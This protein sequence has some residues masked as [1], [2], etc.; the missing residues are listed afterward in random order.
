MTV[1]ARPGLSSIPVYPNAY[2]EAAAYPSDIPVVALVPSYQLP[3]GQS[4]PTSGLS[5]PADYF[6]DAT[7]D[8]SLPDDHAIVHG[9]QKY[10]QISFNHHI[11]FVKAEDVI[12]KP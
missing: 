5:L 2:P 6:Y 1:Q 7:I 12:V 11:G 10:Y 8:S 9:R 4:Y 3:V